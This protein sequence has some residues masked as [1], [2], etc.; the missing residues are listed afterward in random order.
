MPVADRA[1]HRPTRQ[2]WVSSHAGGSGGE[3]EGAFPVGSLVELVGLKTAMAY[4]GQ[5]AE[6]LSVDRSRHR[7]EIRLGDGSVKTIRAENVVLAKQA[8]GPSGR[9]RGRQPWKTQMASYPGG[10]N[11]I[12][13]RHS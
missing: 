5:T 13:S 2:A 12:E 9:G 10:T 8:G 3:D 4:N 1:P 11:R 7:Y 6:V